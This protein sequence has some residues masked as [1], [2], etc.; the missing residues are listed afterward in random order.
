M[1]GRLVGTII[2]QE[3]YEVALSIAG[4]WVSSNITLQEM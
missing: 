4:K 3:P 2:L 1:T